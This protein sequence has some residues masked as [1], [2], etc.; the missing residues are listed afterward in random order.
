MSVPVSVIIPVL[1]EEWNL[2]RCL[3]AV[4]WADQI[5]VVDSGSTDRTRAITEAAGATFVSFQYMGAF[6]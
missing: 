1:N 3:N 5:F 2:E 6:D 4:K